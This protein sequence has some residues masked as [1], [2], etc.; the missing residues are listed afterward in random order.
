MSA[1][2]ATFDTVRN[3]NLNFAYCNPLTPNGIRVGDSCAP[4]NRSMPSNRSWC[5]S[6][7]LNVRMSVSVWS[8]S[9]SFRIISMSACKVFG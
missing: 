7:A 3:I 2:L 1:L 9:S 6:S 5:N 4:A 8:A